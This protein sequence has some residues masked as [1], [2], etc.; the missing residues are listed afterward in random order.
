[1][2]CILLAQLDGI[3]KT[4]IMLVFKVY[5]DVEDMFSAGVKPFIIIWS[6]RL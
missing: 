2:I 3:L 6:I 5:S 4:E 1:M